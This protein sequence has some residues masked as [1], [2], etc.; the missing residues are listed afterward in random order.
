MQ[1]EYWAYAYK[2]SLVLCPIKVIVEVKLLFD[3]PETILKFLVA[4][5]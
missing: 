3:K 4:V 1:E 2:I 5:T